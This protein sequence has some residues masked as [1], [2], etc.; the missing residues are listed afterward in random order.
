MHHENLQRLIEIYKV[1][2]GLCPEIMSE[3]FQFQTQNHHN[4]LD[5][6]NFRIPS[7]NT[8]FQRKQ[9]IFY[10]G[11]KIW[12]QVPDK[13]KSL[14][15]LR[16][17]KKTIKKWGAINVTVQALKNFVKWCWIHIIIPFILNIACVC[18][19]YLFLTFLLFLSSI[20]LLNLYFTL[21]DFNQHSVK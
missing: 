1:V 14:E 8:I 13:I 15:S 5:N 20:F 3:V 2:N 7:F 21:V 19:S 10:L 11:P 9:S 17:F 6:S 18:E 16:S 12:S 4:L